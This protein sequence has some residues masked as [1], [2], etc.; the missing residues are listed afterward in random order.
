MRKA[1]I[2][3]SFDPPTLGHLDV[4]EQACRTYDGVTVGVFINPEKTYR[5][6]T[7]ARVEMLRRMCAHLPTVSVI[8]SDGYVA[9]T[10]REGGFAAIVRG[11]RDP[12][13]LAYEAKMADY[14]LAHSGVPTVFLPPD[15]AHAQISSSLVRERLAAGKDVSDLVPPA[16]C[17]LL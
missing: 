13:D 17:A 14:N 12:A 3:G 5:Y 4:I 9:D 1:L 6:P 16:V 15:P 7:D 8:A 11:V 10:A 2:T